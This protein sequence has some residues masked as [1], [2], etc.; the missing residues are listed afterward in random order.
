[1]MNDNEF[2]EYYP[3]AKLISHKYSVDGEYGSIDAIQW[4][5]YLY[6]SCQAQEYFI[7]SSHCG[8]GQGCFWTNYTVYEAELEYWNSIR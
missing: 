6:Y 5:R 1:M 4:H 8:F 7:V 2:G 3:D